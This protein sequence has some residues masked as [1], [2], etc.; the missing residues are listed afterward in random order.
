MKQ[1]PLLCLF[2]VYGFVNSTTASE[3]RPDV[4]FIIVDD[5]NDWL[6]CLDGHPDAQSPNIDALAASGML[7]SQGYCCL[8]YTSPSPR[9]S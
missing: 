7:F 6:G 4:V 8:L 9:D 1:I 5:L 2:A 3:S